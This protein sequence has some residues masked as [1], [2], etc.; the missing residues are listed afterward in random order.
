M[1]KE[2]SFISVMTAVGLVTTA[3]GGGMYV[4]ALAND[5]ETLKKEKD[6]IEQVQ[7]DVTSNKVALASV[8]ATQTY[9][10][11]KQTEQDKKLDK[12][13]EKLEALD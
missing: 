6:K 5:V 10:L 8:S 3:L 1:R 12:I 9:I 13:L 4:G 7:E 2:A 11:R